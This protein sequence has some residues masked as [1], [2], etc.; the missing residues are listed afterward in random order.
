MNQ[1]NKIPTLSFKEIILRLFSL[2]DAKEVQ[3]QAGDPP[4][5]ATT[6]TIPRPYFDGM[7]EEWIAKHQDWFEKGISAD[8][9]GK[10]FWGNGYCTQAALV[11]I[12]YGFEVLNLNKMTARHMG[13]NPSSGLV[14]Q[15]IGLEKEGHLKN[16][17]IKSGKF[18]DMI[19]FGLTKATWISNY[20]ILYG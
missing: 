7:A 12:K 10:E 19:I 16:E 17:M 15:K 14:K 5:A 8:W 3:R 1:E 9:V 13:Y 4:V 20:K 18:C 11:A 2:N 6:A